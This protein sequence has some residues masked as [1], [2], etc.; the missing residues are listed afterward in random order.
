[1]YVISGSFRAFDRRPLENEGEESRV[2]NN[3]ENKFGVAHAKQTTKVDV[4]TSSEISQFGGFHDFQLPETGDSSS[5][6]WSLN[7]DNYSGVQLQEPLWELNWEQFN[8]L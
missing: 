2:H 4:S 3:I 6:N 8:W 1:M 7:N 5:T